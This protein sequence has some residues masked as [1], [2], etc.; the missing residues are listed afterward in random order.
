M[1]PHASSVNA[2]KDANSAARAAPGAAVG[3][4]NG[5]ATGRVLGQGTAPATVNDAELAEVAHQWA[6]LPEAIRRAV[7]A[8]VRAVP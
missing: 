5:D 3:A 1:S 4:E 7:L 6:T 2:E 8:L